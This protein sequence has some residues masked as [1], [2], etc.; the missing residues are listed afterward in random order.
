[1]NLHLHYVMNFEAGL[2]F[3]IIVFELSIAARNDA[4]PELQKLAFIFTLL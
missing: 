1:M 3:L 4:F 2:F